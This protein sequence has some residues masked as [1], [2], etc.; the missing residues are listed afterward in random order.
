MPSSPPGYGSPSSHS[1]T[2]AESGS[3][4]GG[5][6]ALS[7]FEDAEEREWRQSLQPHHRAI[8]DELRHISN[9]LL[10]HIVDKETAVSNIVDMY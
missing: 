2:S 5:S 7:S 4:N 8:L 6:D 1:S 3:E 9:R 10:S